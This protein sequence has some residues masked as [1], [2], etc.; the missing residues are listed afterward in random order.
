MQLQQHLLWM[1]LLTSEQIPTAGITSVQRS[2]NQEI[3]RMI[4][5][6]Q[7]FTQCWWNHFTHTSFILAAVSGSLLLNNKLVQRHTQSGYICMSSMFYIPSLKYECS[8]P[9][10]QLHCLSVFFYMWFNKPFKCSLNLANNLLDCFPAGL[11]TH[12]YRSK[13]SQTIYFLPCL[14]TSA[15]Q[16]WGEGT[17]FMGNVFIW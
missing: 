2:L 12:L 13:W 14:T 3:T 5:H 15:K 17:V 16:D 9:A 1:W 4:R 7:G 6:T 10:N 8:S 11:R